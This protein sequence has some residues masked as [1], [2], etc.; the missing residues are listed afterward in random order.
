[1]NE[2]FQEKIAF[3]I[4][5]Y[6]FNENYTFTTFRQYLNES[7][8]WDNHDCTFGQEDLQKMLGNNDFL[9]QFRWSGVQE[10]RAIV[11]KGDKDSNKFIILTNDQSKVFLGHCDDGMF[12]VLCELNHKSNKIYPL[13]GNVIEVKKVNTHSKWRRKGFA[14]AIYKS[15]MFE[16]TKIMS[17]AVQYKGAVKIWKSFFESNEGQEWKSMI[18]DKKIKVQLY[19]IITKKIIYDN[20]SD[21]K[22]LTDVDIWSF[23]SSKAN[24]RLVANID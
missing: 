20:I 11:N 16:G 10:Y 15:I 14:T 21:V 1:M 17:D 9:D 13:I 24:L 22:D 12:K 5:E 7:P 3:W 19:D 8:Q 6:N 2:T 23:D 18:D 4:N